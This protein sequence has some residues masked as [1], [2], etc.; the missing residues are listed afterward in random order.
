MDSFDLPVIHYL[1]R[2]SAKV[3]QGWNAIPMPPRSLV[4]LSRGR[5]DL[6]EAIL[7]Q[8]VVEM[9]RVFRKSSDTPRHDGLGIEAMLMDEELRSI[10][11]RGIE[12]K[13]CQCNE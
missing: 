3:R 6:I 8:G 5:G 10:F 4:T 11:R 9:T 1:R 7:K 13:R 2:A 12:R